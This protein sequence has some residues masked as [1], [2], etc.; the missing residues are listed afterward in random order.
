MATR[1]LSTYYDIKD[2]ASIQ[3]LAGYVVRDNEDI[4]D[5]DSNLPFDMFDGEAST[6]DL[7]LII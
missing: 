1:P 4:E 3:M 5:F 6:P 2:F 7:S